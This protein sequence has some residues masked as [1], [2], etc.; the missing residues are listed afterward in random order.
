[1]YDYSNLVRFRGV[2]LLGQPFLRWNRVRQHSSLE[3]GIV[4][5]ITL[6][7]ETGN[8]NRAHAHSEGADKRWKVLALLATGFLGGIFSSMSGLGLDIC[9]SQLSVY[10]FGSMREWQPLPQW[11]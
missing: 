6:I 10:Y 3:K 1:M 11:C 7:E 9:S 5:E 4:W 2:P 8:W